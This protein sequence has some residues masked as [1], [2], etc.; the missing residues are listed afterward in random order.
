MD[1]PIRRYARLP[2]QGDRTRKPPTTRTGSRKREPPF[3]GEWALLKEL[4][5]AD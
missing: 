1:A 3:A 2:G 5:L 4:G